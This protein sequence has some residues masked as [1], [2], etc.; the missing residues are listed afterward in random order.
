MIR[1]S[2]RSDTL[3]WESF[4]PA[5]GVL[6]GTFELAGNY[7]VSVYRSD[8]G[9]YSGTETLIQ[10]GEYSY[11]NVGVSFENGRKMSSW[12]AVIKG[13]VVKEGVE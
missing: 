7:I 10:T 13:T 8:N 12:T 5:L 3:D 4:N 11:D 6:R 1:E 2:G 9:V